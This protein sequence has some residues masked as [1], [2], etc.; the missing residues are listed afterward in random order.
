[1]S[2]NHEGKQECINEKV[3]LSAWKYLDSKY[4]Q[5]RLN[6]SLVLMSCTIH[7]DGKKQAVMFEEVEGEPQILQMII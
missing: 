2:I 3:I 7:L 4:L 5:K 1:M 6:A